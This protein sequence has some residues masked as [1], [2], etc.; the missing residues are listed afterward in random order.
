MSDKRRTPVRSRTVIWL[1]FSAVLTAP[2]CAL[3]FEEVV[4]DDGLGGDDVGR[5][6]EPIIGGTPTNAR[7]EVGLASVGCTAT[8]ISPHLFLTA[9]HCIGHNPRQNGGTLTLD[10]TTLG[11]N[12]VL[13]FGATLDKWD[14]ALG[15]LNTEAPA[16][17]NPARFQT[18]EPAVNS[19]ITMMGFGCNTWNPTGGGGTKRFRTGLY[20]QTNFGCPGDSGGPAFTGAL[21]A[22]GPMFAVDSA[23]GRGLSPDVFG[24][25]PAVA[26][27]LE[28]TIRLFGL[29]LEFNLDRPG[30]DLAGGAAPAPDALACFS[31][32][33]RNHNCKA[34]TF[35]NG[36]CF[37]KTATPPMVPVRGVTSA[38]P[39]DTQ[40][41]FDLRGSDYS[42]FASPSADACRVA[43]ATDS[44][45]CRAYTYFQGTC[46]LKD[47][48]PTAT[49]CSNC[50][51]G[52]GN[53][54]ELG[55]DRP[56]FD[57]RQVAGVTSSTACAN[58]CAKDGA[59]LAFSWVRATDRCFLKT[60]VP[61]PVNG[62]G[63]TS[64]V[65]RG[66]EP[67]TNR[68]GSDFRDFD[69][70]EPNPHLCQAACARENQCV[71]WTMVAPAPGGIKAHCWLKSS[72]PPR[73][74]LD[75]AVSGLKSTEFM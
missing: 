34:M 3:D 71:A 9:A 55:W 42:S 43:C 58:E 1:A 45:R 52:F 50:T 38:I 25:L 19:T 13:G 61:A 29:G 18:F 65:R 14:V 39:H 51:S 67:N 66:L 60:Q 6:Q 8:L 74:G 17:F 41:T 64:G 69:L 44:F 33:Q 75:G 47:G 7:I 10:G 53:R 46:F 36:T 68:A 59:C 56:G 40:G 22:N 48:F 30:F 16:R 70:P 72:V 32:C 20:G 54:L 31:R 12:L 24:L 23:N 62:N 21:G 4:S 26:S 57:G 15:L 63:I 37:M 73:S 5:Q 2:G 11:I 49:E 27:R 28:S 35:A